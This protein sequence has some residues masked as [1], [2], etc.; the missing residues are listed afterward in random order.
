MRVPYPTHVHQQAGARC[1]CGV[2]AVTKP[3]EARVCALL[4]AGPPHVWS[5]LPSCAPQSS[6]ADEENQR[7]RKG[8]GSFKSQRSV[9]PTGC[10]LLGCLQCHH[11]FK[12]ASSL[13]QLNLPHFSQ[14]TRTTL[15]IKN[16]FSRSVASAVKCKGQNLL[17]Q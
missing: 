16:I 7:P 9:S 15:L 2:K 5:L 13:S 10:Y 14:G 6:V 4:W 8:E 1:K 3:R 17:D 12:L 11:E